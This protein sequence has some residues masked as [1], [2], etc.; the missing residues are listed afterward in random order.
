[1]PSVADAGRPGHNRLS[2]NAVR[3][4]DLDVLSRITSSPTLRIITYMGLFGRT[5][6]NDEF[7]IVY[8]NM[9]TAAAQVP[10]QGQGSADRFW[11]FP[12]AQLDFDRESAPAAQGSVA[13]LDAQI[14][15]V[16]WPL[17]CSPLFH[18]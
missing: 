8:F 6:K 16:A 5:P 17:L 15:G 10:P 4:S 11:A 14:K 3:E 1:M 13:L 2:G 12:I 7:E 9:S 18:H